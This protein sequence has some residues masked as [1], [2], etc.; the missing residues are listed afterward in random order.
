MAGYF[1]LN[2]RET[3]AAAYKIE[4]DSGLNVVIYGKLLKRSGSEQPLNFR[5][6]LEH[7]ANALKII[8]HKRAALRLKHCL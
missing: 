2:S 3:A 7:V 5:N 8:L 1:A 6:S 4:E